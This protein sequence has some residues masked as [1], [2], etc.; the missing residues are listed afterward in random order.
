MEEKNKNAPGAKAQPKGPSK[1]EKMFSAIAAIV[2]VVVILI[3]AL[4][5]KANGAF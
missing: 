1:R 2:F 4:V 5:Q 3:V